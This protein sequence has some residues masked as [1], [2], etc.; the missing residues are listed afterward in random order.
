[1]GENR[2]F[3]KCWLGFG[4]MQLSLGYFVADFLNC[5][6]DSELWKDK[7]IFAIT[8]SLFN[9]YI[10]SC[11]I[12]QMCQTCISNS[13]YKM[14]LREHKYCA[15]EQKWFFLQYIKIYNLK[16]FIKCV[17][18]I[19]IKQQKQFLCKSSYKV[20]VCFVTKD[21]RDG[22]LHCKVWRMSTS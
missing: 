2:V 15:V 8:S 7:S 16:I 18:P 1:M 9:L 20:C 10:H 12:Y 6:L 5:L 3:S 13:I 4:V 22:C 11:K 17:L 21:S 19:Y 14:T